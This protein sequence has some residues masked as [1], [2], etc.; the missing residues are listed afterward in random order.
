MWCQG[1]SPHINQWA[2]T[3]TRFHI[4]YWKRCILLLWY[5]ASIMIYLEFLFSI[6]LAI[7]CIYV[8]WK[9]V[10]CLYLCR[11]QSN[12]QIS[13]I[14]WDRQHGKIYIVADHPWGKAINL[15]IRGRLRDSCVCILKGAA[16]CERLTFESPPLMS[17]RHQNQEPLERWHTTIYQY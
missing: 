14:S 1:L 9:A 15:L 13:M 3:Q 5:Q 4:L 16:I 7:T 11:L 17:S 12:L 10:S 8:S 6:L 2:M